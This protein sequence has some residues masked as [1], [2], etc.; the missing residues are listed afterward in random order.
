MT[1]IYK[2]AWIGSQG[3]GKT[4]TVNRVARLLSDTM[5]PFKLVTE[6][7]RLCPFPL[8]TFEGQKWLI[9]EQFRCE[10]EATPELIT[11][12]V[13]PIQ[14]ILCD[15]SLWDGLVYATYL[16]RQGRLSDSEFRIIDAMITGYVKKSAI[17][18]SVIY[19]CE[20][21]ELYDDPKRPMDKDYQSAIY[22][23]FKEIIKERG[24]QVTIIQ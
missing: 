21:K 9:E 11:G 4:T 7:A 8:D 18:Y 3:S 10:T 24:I 6:K 20:P 23:T 17:P 16:N 12:A 14:Y 5:Q 19:L 13:F 15:R 22:K 2:I 1:T